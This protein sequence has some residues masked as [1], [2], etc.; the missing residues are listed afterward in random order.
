MGANGFKNVGLAGFVVE[1]FEQQRLEGKLG[2]EVFDFGPIS[3]CR[4]N[5]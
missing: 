3:G 2:A 4:D 5:R 1:A